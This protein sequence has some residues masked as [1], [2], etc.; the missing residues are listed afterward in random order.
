MDKEEL[1]RF[2]ETEQRSKSN[3]KRIDNLEGKVDDIHRLASSVELLA[4]E[5]KN[6]R[7]DINNMDNRLKEVEEKP[8]K[9][10]DKVKMTVITSITSLII[11]GIGG[12]LIGLIIK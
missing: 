11:G 2:V 10:W 8:A 7:G 5:M 1:E 4:A 12:A 3:T 6:M 9:N